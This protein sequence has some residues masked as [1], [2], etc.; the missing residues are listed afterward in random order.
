MADDS[1][2]ISKEE[3]IWLNRMGGP[4]GW[5]AQLG[6][7]LV[8]LQE[9]AGDTATQLAENADR[10]TNIEGLYTGLSN[11]GVDNIARGWMLNIKKDFTFVDNKYWHTTN[12][13]QGDATGYKASVK[14]KVYAGTK[15]YIYGK[16]NGGASGMVAKLVVLD[17]N[18]NYVDK[19]LYSQEDVFETLV[20]TVAATSYVCISGLADGFIAYYLP[21]IET[22]LTSDESNANRITDIENGIVQKTLNFTNSFVRATD[23][24]VATNSNYYASSAFPLYYGETLH[25]TAQGYQSNVSLIYEYDSSGNPLRN[26]QMGSD[27]LQTVTYTPSKSVE[28]IKISGNVTGFVYLF[29]HNSNVAYNLK[30]AIEVN[31]NTIFSFDNFYMWLFDTGICVGDSLTNGQISGN[32]ELDRSKNYPYFLSKLTGSTITNVSQGGLTASTWWSTYGTTDFASYDFAIIMLGTNDGLTDTLAT[33]VNPYSDP[34]QYADTNTGCYCKIIEKIKADNPNC[35]IFLNT[36]DNE[37]TNGVIRQIATKYSLD[38][39]EVYANTLF[40]LAASDLHGSDDLIH[41]DVCGY[42]TL[43]RLIHYLIC[44]NIKANKLKYGYRTY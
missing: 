13:V 44:Q 28:Y 17:L 25:L 23:G 7:L 35:F 38:V 18:D 9:Q 40:N 22:A 16:V 42:L 15:V 39:N 12:Y 11:G 24:T 3:E 14:T 27:S 6:S 31:P 33:D 36:V 10:L 30:N 19:A 20:Y 8:N 26:V 37:S 29:T 41:F 2:A 4:A 43:A 21:P 5:K 34:S 32:G 1:L